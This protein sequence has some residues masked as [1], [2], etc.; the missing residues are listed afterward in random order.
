MKNGGGDDGSIVSVETNPS[1]SRV[2]CKRSVSALVCGDSSSCSIFDESIVR[3]GDIWPSNEVFF[4]FAEANMPVRHGLGEQT[5]RKAL[6][7]LDG[8]LSKSSMKDPLFRF[9]GVIGLPTLAEAFGDPLGAI[10][11]FDTL[12]DSL[13]PLLLAPDSDRTRYSM[14]GSD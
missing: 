10:F 2:P 12:E 8:V 11:S 1:W 4:G 6:L 3:V 13:V 9:A 7:I 14:L 5:F